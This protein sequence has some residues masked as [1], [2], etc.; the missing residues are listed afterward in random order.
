MKNMTETNNNYMGIAK[1]LKVVAIRIVGFSRKLDMEKLSELKP[2]QEEVCEISEEIM[3]IEDPEY[4][5]EKNLVLAQV[6]QVVLPIPS[7]VRDLMGFSKNNLRVVVSVH[8]GSGDNRW[9]VI[10][11]HRLK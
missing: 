8:R 2:L 6:G 9:V 3:R 5:R 7:G 4:K 10:K 11:P 1:R